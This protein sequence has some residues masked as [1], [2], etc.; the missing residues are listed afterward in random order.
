MLGFVRQIQCFEKTSTSITLPVSTLVTVT[1]P[2]FEEKPRFCQLPSTA[3]ARS[4]FPSFS[5]TASRTASAILCS[6]V[7]L[8][9]CSKMWLY[10]ENFVGGGG[11][12]MIPQNI[13]A[14]SAPLP[15]H[16]IAYT[17]RVFSS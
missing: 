9:A 6:Q 7:S 13:L 4:L 5:S 11:R 14:D 8:V 10:F 17:S 16:R 2:F 15:M 1:K 3:T 12:F